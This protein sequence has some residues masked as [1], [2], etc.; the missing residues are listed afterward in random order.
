MTPQRTLPGM[1]GFLGH[2]GHE[3]VLV[4]DSTAIVLTIPGI[5]LRSLNASFRI[6]S[7]GALMGARAKAKAQRSQVALLLRSYHGT[8]PVPPLTVTITRIAP[9]ELDDDNLA[10]SAKAVRDGVA[11]WLGVDDRTKRSGVAWRYAQARDGRSYGVTIRI[12]VSAQ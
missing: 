6:S 12:E 9:S 10:G 4:L 1:R 2:T 8:P 5:R 3:P 7:M 11:D